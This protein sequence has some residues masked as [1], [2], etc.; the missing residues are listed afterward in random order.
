MG[1]Q[2]SYPPVN[3]AEYQSGQLINPS[4]EALT[5]DC[6]SFLSREVW[7][8]IEDTMHTSKPTKAEVASISQSIERCDFEAWSLEDLAKAL[9]VGCTALPA[10]CG[11]TRKLDMWQ[12]QQL[13]FVDVDND[14]AMIAKGF[15]P[16]G[17]TYAVER[18]NT[19][20][21]PLV[22]SYETFSSSPTFDPDPAKQRFRLVFA[23]DY[24]EQDKAKAEAFGSA[25]L[26]AFP[27]SD[28]TT[29]QPNR[30]FFGT[31]KEVNVWFKNIFPL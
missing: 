22:M 20:G 13:W 26:A 9:S 29:A 2:E 18:C 7:A 25:L 4:A 24:I 8:C 30:L 3:F 5:E 15:A 21:L 12:A 31:N 23:L 1:A 28:P 16:L 27:E 6:K 17:Y 11:G 10:Y 19:L 14:P